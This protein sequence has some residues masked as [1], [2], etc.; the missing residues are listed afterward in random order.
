MEFEKPNDRCY[1]EQKVVYLMI[2][3]WAYSSHV[4]P[5]GTTI[6]WRGDSQK[7]LKKKLKI[8]NVDFPKQ[9]WHIRC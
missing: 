4:G 1:T 9:G 3:F 5:T 8:F 7:G 6:T 2:T